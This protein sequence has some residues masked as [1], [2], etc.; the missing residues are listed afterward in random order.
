MTTTAEEKKRVDWIDLAKGLCMILVV[1][2]HTDGILPSDMEWTAESMSYFRMPLYFLLSGIFFKTYGSFGQFLC[3]KFDHLL[4][5]YIFFYALW[6][7][8]PQL[9]LATIWFLFALFCSNVLFFGIHALTERL[10]RKW[11]MPAVI[12]IVG[13]GGY[14]CH[15]DKSITFS[16]LVSQH[17]AYAECGMTCLPFFC[18]GY[19]LRHGTSL[20]EQNTGYSAKRTVFVVTALVVVT[21]GG[22]YEGWGDTTHFMNTYEIPWWAMYSLGLI[23][24]LMVLQL[25]SMAGRIPGISYIGRYSIVV[26]ITHKPLILLMGSIVGHEDTLWQWLVFL[27][28]LLAEIPTIYVCIRF[29][30]ILFAQKELTV[31]I[32]RNFTPNRLPRPR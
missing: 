11:L 8:C 26:L 16:T 27:T 3:K 1:F 28:V 7:A 17:I 25:A 31:M 2:G 18:A 21:L 15:I 20:L 22:W 19:W 29:L 6:I 23:G 24:S 5:P 13:V 4:V 12:I 30:P 32:R 14:C 10:H 9:P